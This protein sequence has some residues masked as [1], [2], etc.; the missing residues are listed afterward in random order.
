[1]IGIISFSWAVVSTCTGKTLARGS[2]WIYAA[3]E[4]S[5]FWLVVAMYCL[6][7]LLFLGLYLLN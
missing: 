3:K 7:A 4:P 1:M 5:T 2:G 6:A